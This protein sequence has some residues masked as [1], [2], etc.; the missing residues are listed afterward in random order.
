MAQQW[1]QHQLQ[2]LARHEGAR[3]SGTYILFT[4][5]TSNCT[6]V[7]HMRYVL[8]IVLH[9]RSRQHYYNRFVIIYVKETRQYALHIPANSN[10]EIPTITLEFSSTR[11]L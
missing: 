2:E 10:N 6:Y 4:K 3:S 11:K 9:A 5:K 7:C 1:H 8:S